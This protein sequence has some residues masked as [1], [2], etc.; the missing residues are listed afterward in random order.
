MQ[1]PDDEFAAEF[2]R[3]ESTTPM[4]AN[5]SKAAGNPASAESSLDASKASNANAPATPATAANDTNG[6][7]GSTVS[8]D[9]SENAQAAAQAKMQQLQQLEERLQARQAELDAREAASRQSNTNETQTSTPASHADDDPATVLARDFG[10]DF[11]E[12]VTKLVMQICEKQI[13]E[14]VGSVA[15]TVDQLIQ[16]LT[17]ERQHNHFK[18]IAAAHADFMEVVESPEFM[19]WKAAQAP[20]KQTDIARVIASGSA[21]EI[22]DMLTAFKQSKASQTTSHANDDALDAAEGVRSSGIKLPK[23]PTPADD[24]A[25]AWNEA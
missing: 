17:N 7:N 8:G 14:G 24:F 5:D 15:A 20:A 13:G 12:L 2:N 4:T 6:S 10:E 9:S 23:A 11:V 1:N 18:T 25:A 19:A 22:I 16:Q 3:D 21:Q